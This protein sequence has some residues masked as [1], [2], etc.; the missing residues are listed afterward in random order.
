MHTRTTH[1]L[2]AGIAMTMGLSACGDDS[3]SDPGGNTGGMAGG[4]GGMA[5][6]AGGGAGGEMMGG[7]GGEAGGAG[8]G[9]AGGMID[10]DLD[11]DGDG[12]T[13]VDEI[14]QHGTN[15]LVADTD[16]DGF[17]DFNEV[18]E[19]AFDP[20]N[21]NFQFNPRIADVPQYEIRLTST[22]QFYMVYSEGNQ[23]G[24]TV[25]TEHE[26]SITQGTTRSWGGS[27]SHS[28]EMTHTTGVEISVEHEFGL[29]GGTT[30]S[31]SLSY[32]FSHSTTNETSTNW[33]QDQSRE[34][35][36]AL[37][38]IEQT[39]ESESVEITGGA[40]ATTVV[41]ENTGHIAFLLEDLTLSAFNLD[42]SNPLEL[43]SIGNLFYSG[44]DL[45][46]RTVVLP[47]DTTAPLNFAAEVDLP[48]IKDVLADSR[49]VVVAPAT[50][51]VLDQDG[52]SFE[53]EATNINAR[54][55]QVILDFG[56]NRAQESYRVATALGDDRQGVTAQ[57]VLTD[58]LRVPY[59]TGTS[60]WRFDTNDAPTD[61]FTGVT[62]VRGVEMNDPGS[63]YWIVAHTYPTEAGAGTETDYY[64]P[65]VEDFDFD[66][67]VLKSG[68]ILHLVYIE[69]MDRD[70]LGDR[71]EFLYGTDP[72]NPDTDGDGCSDSLEAGGWIITDEETG[73]E[74]R[75]F[76]SPLA[77]DTDGDTVSD[78]DE[79]EAGTD[80][81]DGALNLAPEITD[82]RIDSRGVAAI[83]TVTVDD[84]NANI[85]DRVE[86]VRIN[87]GDGRDE[88]VLLEEGMNQ[89]TVEHVYNRSETFSIE[90][91]A[92]DGA[93]ASEPTIRTFEPQVPTQDLLLHYTFDRQSVNGQTMEDASNANNDGEYDNPAFGTDRFGRG[94]RAGDLLNN[95]EADN[96]GLVSVRNVNLGNAFTF[97]VW[98]SADSRGNG[99]RILG[100]GNGFNLYFATSNKVAFG[101]LDGLQPDGAEARDMGTHAD[102]EW[103]HYVGVALPMDGSTQLTLYRNGESV[104]SANMPGLIVDNGCRIYAGAFPDGDQCNDSRADEFSGFPGLMDD[105]RVY[106][107][108]LSPE[109]I[110]A[111]YLEPD[112]FR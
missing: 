33:N 68:H 13:D 96:L 66:G 19:K 95:N 50:G 57:Q 10:P 71:A 44:A 102:N 107:R 3:S 46:P 78:C 67:L 86:E 9:G 12:L 24:R 27:Q 63:A 8:E 73:E 56:Q 39:E 81:T 16:G 92:W 70:G 54:T 62:A 28:V 105:V 58:I 101:R 100:K 35:T 36:N 72:E 47:G 79:F 31:A 83:L 43:G 108:A 52:R 85:G 91:M 15:P 18:V 32:E 20:E 69:D 17:D 11:T 87:W 14:N 97:S 103:T 60:P 6:G 30:A 21:N 59:T 84:P 45:F 48:T 41:V 23:T 88:V 26:Q 98:I 76:P 106:N 112:S 38:R 77:I 25:G 42:P 55:A 74:R 1:T 53:L 64:N 82:L 22:P 49:N 99:E 93:L 61:S 111:L 51:V 94:E 7:A 34:N 104:A 29:T 40:V 90:V 109:E 75:V 89:V 37:A 2:L 5:G 80:P 110:S 65:I 4:A